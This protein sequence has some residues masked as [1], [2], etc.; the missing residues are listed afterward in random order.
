MELE[1]FAN[2]SDLIARSD[3]VSRSIRTYNEWGLMPNFAFLSTVYPCEL[4][5]TFIPFP[6]FPE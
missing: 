4:V 6:K 5:S 2:A 1:K 3:T